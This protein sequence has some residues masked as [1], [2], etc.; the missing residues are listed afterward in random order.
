MAKAPHISKGQYKNRRAEFCRKLGGG[1]AVLKTHTMKFR[2]IHHEY[3]FRAES[4][5]LYLTGCSEPEAI[6][7]F[8]PEHQHKFTLFLSKPD[9]AAE[10]WSG[11]RPTF[12]EA[13]I[14]YGADAVFAIEQFEEI[15]A[16]RLS[17]TGKIFYHVGVDKS[18]NDRMLTF[19]Q[20][21]KPLSRRGFNV[22]TE[23]HDTHSILPWMRLIKSPEEIA[24]IVHAASITAEGHLAAM[25]ETKPGMFENEVEALVGYHFRK[26]G[27]PAHA[28]LPIVASGNHATTLHYNENNSK[29]KRGDL[30]LID[31]GAEYENYASDVTRTFPVSGKFSKEQKII[32]ELVLKAQKTVLDMIRPGILFSTLQDRATEILVEGLVELKILKG[33]PKTIIEKKAHTKFY[34]HGIGHWL[35]LDTHDACPYKTQNG[36]GVTLQEGMVF[37]VEPG[38]YFNA[39]LKDTPK[40]FAGIGIR[41]EDDVVV[42]KKGCQV[43]T[44]NIPKEIDDIESLMA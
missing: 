21:T 4:N 16:Q 9:P 33:R 35:G 44:A 34:M 37:T 1:T 5:F 11:K 25:K 29:I 15:L 17:S 3:P 8:S 12:E 7:I 27:S 24:M 19:I 22:P 18:F 36:K 41:I 6:A 23:L 30:V 42:T 43:L 26:N 2:N 20:R 39:Q 31:C 38:L 14:R 10:V 32:Y 40:R 13:R 28:Y